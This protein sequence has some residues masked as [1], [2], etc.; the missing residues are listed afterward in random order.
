MQSIELYGINEFGGMFRKHRKAKGFTLE[1]VHERTGI[2]VASLSKLENSKLDMSFKKMIE[3][4]AFY[5]MNVNLALTK[6]ESVSNL[7]N[8]KA[9][10][11]RQ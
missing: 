3:L 1:E 2:G 9:G 6:K 5:G 11:K 10:R 4:M 8:F 7:R